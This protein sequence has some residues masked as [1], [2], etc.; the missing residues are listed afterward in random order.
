MVKGFWIHGVFMF[1]DT[2]LNSCVKT[3]FNNNKV[4]RKLYK[5]YWNQVLQILWDNLRSEEKQFLSEYKR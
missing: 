3:K 4:V 2:A 1:I 5:P